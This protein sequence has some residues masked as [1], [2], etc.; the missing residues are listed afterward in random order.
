MAASSGFN[1]WKVGEKSLQQSLK[2]PLKGEETCRRIQTAVS[3]PPFN[4]SL[5]HLNSP[6][7]FMQ[8]LRYLFILVDCSDC[9]NV[10]LTNSRWDVGCCRWCW[11][12]SADIWLPEDFEFIHF[13]YFYFF[14]F[15]GWMHGCSG[16]MPP[17]C[18]D[19]GFRRSWGKGTAGAETTCW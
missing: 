13:I 7:R 2:R 3:A 16:L 12:I 6:L 15:N 11:S 10:L 4:A 5:L 19:V 8:P 18:V 17:Q 1:L 9:V 14:C